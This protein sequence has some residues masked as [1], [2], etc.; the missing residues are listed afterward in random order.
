MSRDKSDWLR[1][2]RRLAAL[3]MRLN[4]PLSCS[5]DPTPS[6]NSPS[7]AERL[8]NLPLPVVVFVLLVHHHSGNFKLC[9]CGNL[10]SERSVAAMAAIHPSSSSSSF[11]GEETSPHRFFLLLARK[12]WWQ[13]AKQSGDEGTEKCSISPSAPSRKQSERKRRLMGFG[14]AKITQRLIAAKAQAELC[15]HKFARC[16]HGSE[17]SGSRAEV[18]AALPARN[19]FSMQ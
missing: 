2:P 1:H 16:S 5:P 8:R 18:G 10:R 3:A 13:K 17:S 14:P 12:C 9:N 19:R 7:A 4:S 15:M 11:E 6:R